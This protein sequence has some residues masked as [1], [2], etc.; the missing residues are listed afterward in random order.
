METHR[1]ETKSKRRGREFG[2]KRGKER[3]DKK[4]NMRDLKGGV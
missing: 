1:N 2:K 4:L 3:E